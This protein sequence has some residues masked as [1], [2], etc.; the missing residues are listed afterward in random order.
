[1]V[2]ADVSKIS[3]IAKVRILAEQ[4]IRR[5][6]TFHILSNKLPI[7]MR[8]SIDDILTVCAALCNFKE[9]IYVD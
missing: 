8:S 2:P 1:M 7:S 6:K 3:N 9:P 4:V 5:M